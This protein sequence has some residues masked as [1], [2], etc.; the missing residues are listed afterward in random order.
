MESVLSVTNLVLFLVGACLMF[1]MAKKYKLR[2]V[3]YILVGLFCTYFFGLYVF[4]VFFDPVIGLNTAIP[5]RIGLF[6]LSSGIIDS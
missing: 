2:R 1:R 5:A 3:V 6:L 4:I